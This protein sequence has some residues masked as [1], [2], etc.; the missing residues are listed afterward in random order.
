M[1]N[2]ANERYGRLTLAPYRFEPR[3]GEPVDA[4]R[5]TLTVPENRRRSDSNSI[6]LAF[7]RFPATTSEPGHPV[8]FL[9]GG[10]GES[11]IQF[12][13]GAHF[14][15][16]MALR[17]VGDV[18]ALDQRGTGDSQPSLRCESREPWLSWDRSAVREEVLAIALERSRACA[19]TLREA[20]IDPAGYN[21]LESVG[22]VDDL[23]VALGA[24][25]FHL[26][27]MSYG[28][29]LAFAV[30][31]KYSDYVGRC[32]L[33]GA[34]G[35]DHTY[36]LPSII[37]GQLKHIGALCADHPVWRN[38]VPDFAA[39]VEDVLN[40]LDRYPVTVELR[41]PAGGDA[42]TLGIG[43]F[44]VE[45]ATAVGMADTRL[46]SLLP[47][48]YAGMSRGDF[49]LPSR[50][51]LLAKYLL[52]LKRGLGR[53]AMG[54]IVDCASGATKERWERIEH[55]ARDAV[56]GRTIDFP[57]PEIGEVW[58]S[59]DLGDEYRSPVRAG[60]SMLFFS[61]SLDC[62]TPLENIL[63]VS[64][65][66]PNSDTIIVEE[67]GHMDVFLFCPDAGEIVSRFLRGE[68]VDTQPRTAIHPF[69]LF[70][71]S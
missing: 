52:L 30:L 18:I 39:M 43:R 59:P 40:R 50:E 20:D 22:D 25:K 5:G 42:T 34:E 36:K 15:I 41:G 51:P 4:Q 68:E 65:G 46:L 69:S 58:G 57:F 23:R 16:F 2:E 62:R 55:E 26:W 12:A 10:P 66:L 31:K 63:E 6:Q 27:G 33:G 14:P 49:S 48:W 47:A 19:D 3:R 29:H 13:R 54:I 67:A 56:L 7:V 9:A 44:D 21:T 1:M 32:V 71:V 60:N 17:E 61:G 38:R 64:K 45:Y 37:Q 35:P 8:L 53:N 28:T 70:S 24:E 11:G